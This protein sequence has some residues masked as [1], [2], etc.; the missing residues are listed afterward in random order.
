MTKR[1]IALCLAATAFIASQS[2]LAAPLSD[3]TAPDGRYQTV[4]P[5]GREIIVQPVYRVEQEYVVVEYPRGSRQR[6]PEALSS[7]PPSDEL[8][9]QRPLPAQ[10]RYFAQRE[11]A[12]RTASCG[13]AFDEQPTYCPRS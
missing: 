3:A 13:H 8:I 4:T 12:T 10:E 1:R 11:A 5:D 7:W 9:G 2:G 6:V